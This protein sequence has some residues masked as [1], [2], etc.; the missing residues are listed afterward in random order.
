MIPETK[1]ASLTAVSFFII[2]MY[3]RVLQDEI[4]EFVKIIAA[5]KRYTFSDQG[6]IVA[7]ME[8]LHALCVASC[9]VLQQL[10]GQPEPPLFPMPERSPRE[11][12]EPDGNVHQLEFADL[13]STPHTPPA[14]KKLRRQIAGLHRV[15]N[16]EREVN[17]EERRR[18]RLKIAYLE[19]HV[20]KLANLLIEKNEKIEKLSR[21]VSQKVMRGS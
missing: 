6:V 5:C 20:S 9:S 15:L 12:D 13:D 14:L 4:R 18:A 8:R 3:I 21:S 1:C 16:S 10:A 19:D 17:R 11:P 7:H 2:I